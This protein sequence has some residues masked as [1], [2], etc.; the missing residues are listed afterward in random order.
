MNSASRDRLTTS[1]VCED[2]AGRELFIHPILAFFRK[3]S[4]C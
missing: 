2:Q 1:L 4:C 3:N